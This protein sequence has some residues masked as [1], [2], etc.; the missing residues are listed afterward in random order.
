AC[1]GVDVIVG[2]PGE[3][4]EDF[5]ETYRFINDLD[6]S[7]LHVFTYSE[8]P[9]TPAAL[10]QGQ[11]D[12]GERRR[13]NQMLG[14]LSEKKRRSFYE[15]HLGETRPVL[16]EKHKDSSKLAGFT[17]NY[18]KIEIPFQEDMINRIQPVRLDQFNAEGVVAAELIAPAILADK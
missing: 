4:E 15:Q 11:V 10:M 16:F 6:I 9:N 2:F 13:R 14:I 3:T 1:I 18:V 8:R 12:M 17:D 7:Y 5:L